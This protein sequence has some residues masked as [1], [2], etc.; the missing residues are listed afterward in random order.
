MERQSVYATEMLADGLSYNTGSS[1]EDADHEGF[2][3][4]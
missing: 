4:F 1:M 3:V 2:K